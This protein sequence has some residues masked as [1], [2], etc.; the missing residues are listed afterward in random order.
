MSV[1]FSKGARAIFPV[2]F[3]I[4]RTFCLFPP[5]AS[6]HYFSFLKH[7]I[8]LPNV[9]SSFIKA[10]VSRVFSSFFILTNPLIS[11]YALLHLISFL[12]STSANSSMSFFFPFIIFS[13]F[14]SFFL[15]FL[16]D[17]LSHRFASDFLRF[18]LTS[19]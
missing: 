18:S 8:C 14:P 4:R 13:S 1:I 3:F 15:V 7:I 16:R 6:T 9:A 19:S 2:I 5:L 11:F 12:I 10:H 17:F